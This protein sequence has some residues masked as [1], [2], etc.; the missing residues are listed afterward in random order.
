MKRLLTAVVLA[1][2]QAGCGLVAVRS[3]PRYEPSA[4]DALS[5]PPC[6]HS[7]LLPVADLAVAAGSAGALLLDNTAGDVAFLAG[8]PT[9]TVTGLLGVFTVQG[10]RDWM[11]AARRKW[12][13]QKQI[14]AVE[15]GRVDLLQHSGGF[16]AG[17]MEHFEV[18]P[19][20]VRVEEQ[21]GGA[22]SGVVGGL[23]GYGV[24]GVTRWRAAD[25]TLRQRF[26]RYSMACP[27]RLG[28]RPGSVQKRRGPSHRPAPPGDPD[29]PPN[30]ST[31]PWPQP[32]M[33]S[34][35]PLWVFA[36]HCGFGLDDGPPRG[37][38]DDAW[39]SRHSTQFSRF[40]GTV[41]QDPVQRQ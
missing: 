24:L 3:A 38:F 17:R 4:R 21:E 33:T 18:F 22:I 6:T 30:R 27:I 35:T 19:D 2:T 40:R 29:V 15:Q 7:M 25:Q 11:A 34:T 37:V 9:F 31:G 23:G 13:L 10:C 14:D 1:L 12:E 26:D 32:S 8:A 16:P 36:R 39:D 28:R 5:P 20:A 41:Q